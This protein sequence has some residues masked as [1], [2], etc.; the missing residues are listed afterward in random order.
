MTRQGWDMMVTKVRAGGLSAG[1][2]KDIKEQSQG[3]KFRW[4]FGPRSEKLPSDFK[5]RKHIKTDFELFF[6]IYTER[7]VSNF[8]SWY[9]F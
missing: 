6:S 4:R 3:L 1:G 7:H 5:P 9:G 8:G 2:Q